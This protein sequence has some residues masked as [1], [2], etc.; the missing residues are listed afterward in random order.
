MTLLRSLLI[1]A[2][3][4]ASFIVAGDAAAQ[5]SYDSATDNASSPYSAQYDNWKY[6][7]LGGPSVADAYVQRLWSGA[8]NPAYWPGPTP[9]G[10]GYFYPPANYPY[11]FWHLPYRDVPAP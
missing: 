9:I 3:L 1:L 7:V 6:R 5:Q 2:I 8:Y 10:N 4:S 11:R